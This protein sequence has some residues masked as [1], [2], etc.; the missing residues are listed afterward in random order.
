MDESFGEKMV[1]FI[2][3]SISSTIFFEK[4]EKNGGGI[5][6]CSGVTYERY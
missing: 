3:N 2:N 1:G 5:W 6:I 4:K